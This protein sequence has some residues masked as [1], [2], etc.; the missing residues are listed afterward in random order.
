MKLFFHET[1]AYSEKHPALHFQQPSFRSLFIRIAAREQ[2][3]TLFWT[4][5][6]SII[7]SVAERFQLM[8]AFQ[9]LFFF[10]LLF[11][12]LFFFIIIFLPCFF[13]FYPI[14]LIFKIFQRSFSNNF[15][16]INY[17]FRAL[18]ILRKFS[19]FRNSSLI[20]KNFRYRCTLYQ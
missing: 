13:F 14:H 7:Q 19:K 4:S 5:A 16:R 8:H 9:I 12:F 17:D 10:F 11:L 3:S 2:R 15:R 6:F 1:F 20:I 18:L